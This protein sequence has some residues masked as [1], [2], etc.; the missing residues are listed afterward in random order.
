MLTSSPAKIAMTTKEKTSAPAIAR[1]FERR[2]PARLIS[3]P[4][5][6]PQCGK[7]RN[8]EKKT[9]ARI[10]AQSE[11]DVSVVPPASITVW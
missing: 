10:V 2:L 5:I 9:A 3:P 8:R 1:M 7:A 4:C 11:N 6:T